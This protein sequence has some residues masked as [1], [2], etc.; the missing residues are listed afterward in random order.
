M[1]ETAQMEIVHRKYRFIILL[2]CVLSISYF[3]LPMML[4]LFPDFVETKVIGQISII[5]IYTFLQ[6]PITWILGW[7]YYQKAKEFDRQIE[8]LETGARRIM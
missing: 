4:A 2:I 7:I 5:W 6:I 3:L 1:K 8:E